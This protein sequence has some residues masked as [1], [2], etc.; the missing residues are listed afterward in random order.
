MN[1]QLWFVRALLT[2]ALFTE[3]S[4]AT[5]TSSVAI[6]TCSWD[7]LK[8]HKPLR[9]DNYK[10]YLS[11]SKGN[12]ELI[13][14]DSF[15]F[16]PQLAILQVKYNKVRKLDDDSFK[17]LNALQELN[18]YDNRLT[19]ISSKVFKTLPLLEKLDLGMNKI[20]NIEDG[21]FDSLS[22]LKH[23]NLGFNNLKVIPKTINSLINLQILNLNNNQ[24]SS[25]KANTFTSL[26]KLETL[27]LN[28]NNIQSI[29]R[30]FFKHFNSLSKLDLSSNYLAN[31]DVEDLKEGA[32]KLS[33]I[34]LSINSFK[35]DV[36][37]QIVSKFKRYNIEVTRGVSKSK[38]NIEGITC[39]AK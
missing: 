38:N 8:E 20:S 36:L 4:N 23:L 32:V 2:I 3:L 5:C 13:P 27:Q 33:A 25:L 16:L 6:T 37:S 17:G 34:K 24:I 19:L 18:L 15:K 10:Q 11:I 30:N 14:S 1:N 12:L 28:D 9:L 7:S 26:K 31:L 39:I 35:C 22:K 29:E 21:A